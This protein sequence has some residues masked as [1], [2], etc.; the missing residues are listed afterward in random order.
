MQL[1]KVCDV[2]FGEKNNTQKS[3]K[4]LFFCINSWLVVLQMLKAKGI[5]VNPREIAEKI[6][7]NLPDNELIQKTEIAGPGQ[8]PVSGTF[9]EK[10]TSF[11]RNVGDSFWILNIRVLVWSCCV[12]VGWVSPKF[13]YSVNV[14]IWMLSL[15]LH[16]HPPEEDVCVQTVEQAA[17]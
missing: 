16:Q 15:R 5:K 3:G 14:S 10:K 7:R 2:S 8:C 6:I 1:T 9:Q 13:L 12:S 17:D 4:C 11:L